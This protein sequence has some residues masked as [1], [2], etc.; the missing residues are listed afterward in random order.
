MITNEDKINKNTSFVKVNIPPQ[1]ENYIRAM[2]DD[3]TKP[4]IRKNFRDNVES[5]RN[6]CDE[7]IRK[8][9]REIVENANKDVNRK[10]KIRAAYSYDV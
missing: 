7:A 10:S 9:D 2:F 8:F 1:V 4:N 3:T 5:I 6:I